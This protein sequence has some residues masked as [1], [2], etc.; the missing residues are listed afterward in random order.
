M[1]RAILFTWE[2]WAVWLAVVVTLLGARWLFHRSEKSLESYR[3]SRNSFFGAV[4]R[5]SIEDDQTGHEDYTR[6][7]RPFSDPIPEMTV[8]RGP[9]VSATIYSPSMPD[10][11]S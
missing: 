11:M 5:R 1:I 9:V 3:T 4:P 2:F 10:W 6:P 7:I 8:H